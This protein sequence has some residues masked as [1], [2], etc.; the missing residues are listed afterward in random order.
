MYQDATFEELG[1]SENVLL[2]KEICEIFLENMG[3]RQGRK[4]GGCGGCDAPP[5]D[6]TRQFT[7]QLDPFASINFR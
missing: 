3:T 4:Y 2:A 1:H 7:R 6:K 5:T